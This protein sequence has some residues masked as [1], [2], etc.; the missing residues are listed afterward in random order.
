MRYI[1]GPQM[2]LYISLHAVYGFI[3]FLGGR[4]VQTGSKNFFLNH[5]LLTV[6]TPP[7]SIYIYIKVYESFSKFPGQ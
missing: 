2:R 6:H 5:N 3:A 1:Y 4:S 7:E